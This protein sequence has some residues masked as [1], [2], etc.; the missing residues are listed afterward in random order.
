MIAR[1]V[2]AALA[3]GLLPPASADAQ[4]VMLRGRLVHVD[5]IATRE[6][7]VGLGS[8]G[9]T[10]TN[11][12]GMFE[13]EL[14][15]GVAQVAVE[16]VGREWTV[17]YPRGG[18]VA[19]PRDPGVAVEVV[20]GETVEAATLRLFAEQHERLAS[21]LER[22][23]AEQGEIQA[24]LE[25]FVEDVTARLEMSE[26]EMRRAIEQEQERLRHYPELSATVSGYLIA[27]RDLNDYFK[28]YGHA[29]FEDRDAFEGL[30]Q[31]AEAYNGAFQ[32][33]RSD[34]MAFEYQVGTY[35]ESEELLSDLRALF[36]YALGEVHDIRMLPLNASLEVMWAALN[37]R[38]PDREAVRRAREAIDRTVAELDLRLPEL[39]RR[40]ERVL[41]YL[42]RG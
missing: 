10:V 26:A 6:V 28:R 42:T 12:R 41:G 17:L 4:G 7:R 5:G 20:V 37:A 31:Q 21:R 15:A 34:R 33:L 16:V 1:L 30:R 39:E 2:L 13:A 23:G 32:K 14:P 18:Q 3:F 11:D 40:A 9:S 35:W 8:Y 19:I 24:V 27:A 38:R 36:D 22:V 25:R 29:A